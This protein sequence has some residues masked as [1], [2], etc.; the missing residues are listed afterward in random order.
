MRVAASAFCPIHVLVE[1][2]ALA[3]G[4]AD[5][6]LWGIDGAGRDGR[7]KAVSLGGVT[8]LAPSPKHDI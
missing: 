4:P 8:A 7:C 5:A 6:D 1:L 2:V 3:A